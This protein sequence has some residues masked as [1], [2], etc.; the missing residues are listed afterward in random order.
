MTIKWANNA[1]TTIAGTITPASTTVTLAAGTGAEFPSPTGGDLFKATFYDQAT[2]TIN[3]I[4]HCTAR[5]GDVCTIVRAQEGTVAGTWNAGDIFANLITAGTL[6]AFVQSGT[7]PAANTTIVYTGDDTSTTPNLIICNTNPVPASLVLGMQFNIRVKNTNTGPTMVQL[8]GTAGMAATRL[9]GVPLVPNDVTATQEMIF[10]YNGVNL[11]SLASN[12]S[13]QPP[14][15]IFYVRPDGNDNNTGLSNTPAAAFATVYGAIYA[16]KT[17]YISLLSVTINVADGTYTGGF[18]IGGGYIAG[19]NIVGNI[20]NPGNVI[21]DA[22]GLSPPPNAAPNGFAC[23]ATSGGYATVGGF[24]FKSYYSNAAAGGGGSAV[25]GS[26]GSLYLHDCHFT[27]PLA[28]GQQTP[29]IYAHNG[30]FI[31]LYGVCSF[32]AGG[33]NVY[34]MFQG[35]G[36]RFQLGWHDDLLTQTLTFAFTDAV[37]MNQATGVATLGGGLGFWPSQITFTGR[38]NVTGMEYYCSDAGGLASA[39]AY[40]GILPGTVPGTVVPPGYAG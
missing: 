21:I 32:T 22:T 11:T 15:T 13:N 29:V 34:S 10:V 9:N 2:K 20:S 4:V 39:G 30:G 37:T 1:S 18:L 5:S 25:G 26:G 19:W 31:R 17:R 7:V 38:G 36:G 40:N 23:S 6:A 14:Q 35:E 27:P 24:T 3:E 28:T 8:N 12:I 16:I 33:R